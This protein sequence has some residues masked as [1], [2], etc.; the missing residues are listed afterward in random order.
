MKRSLER[1]SIWSSATVVAAIISGVAAVLAATLPWL[2]GT[3]D[4]SGAAREEQAATMALPR[5]IQTAPSVTPIGIGA[6]YVAK[7]PMPNLT[8]GAWTIVNSVDEAGTDFSGSTLKFTSQR[9]IAGGLEAVGVFEWRK[10]AE[11][12]GCEH[13]VANFDASSRQLFIEGKYV[14]NANSGNLAIGSYSARVSD[15]GRQLV[16][17]TW[18]NTPGSLPGILGKWEAR[19]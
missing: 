2:L 5:P 8:F 16:A 11:I 10:G 19:R 3:H 1:P 9:E 12:V 18:G 4:S 14:E 13:V 15:D 7:K 17:G 6:P